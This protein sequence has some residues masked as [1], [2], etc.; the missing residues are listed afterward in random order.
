LYIPR[1]VLI[2]VVLI[3]FFASCKESVADNP[4]NKSR[5]EKLLLKGE[6]A[7]GKINSRLQYIDSA[8]TA[9][10][11]YK[12]D[13]ITRLYYRRAAVAYFNLDAYRKSLKSGKEVYR[14]GQKANDSISMAK[15]LYFSALSHYQMG[16]ND[17]AF[18]YY[19]GAEKLYAHLDDSSMLGEVILYKAYIY[20]H[21]G[22]YV[23][24]ETEA[25]K[26]LKLFDKNS[27]IEIYNCYLLIANALE[28]QNNNEEAIKY[29]NDALREVDGFKK[30]G[31]DNSYINSA[32]ATCY[33][34][35]GF[36]YLK[37]GDFIK[38][39]AIY[40]KALE[41]LGLSNSDTLVYARLLDNL[42]YARFKSG[43][44][45]NLPMLFFEALKL[46]DSLGDKAGVVNSTY[47]LGEYYL[48]QND[49]IN[50]VTHISRAYQKAKQIKSYYDIRNSLKLLADIDKKNS[51]FY[52][53][54]YVWVTDSLAE[55]TLR[56]REKFA[57]VTYE[58]DKLQDENL[59]LAR[60][61]SLIIG[62]A[63][64]VLLFGGAVFI[65]Y[66]L[67]SR[68][69]E[70]LLLQE[71]Q[72]ANEEI[73][74]LMFEQQ[75]KIDAAR[76]E[77][78]NRIA[79]ELHDGILNNIYAV[80]LNLEFSNRKTDD[81]TVALRKGYIKELQ[82]VEGEIRAVSHNLSR[83]TIFNQNNDFAGI[84]AYLVTSQ[85]NN[86]E[87][88][89]TA[90][91][92]KSIDWERVPGTLKINIYRI[93]QEALQNINKYSKAQ[94]ADLEI[95]LDNNILKV[96]ITDNGVG[97]DTDEI[98]GGIGLKN[99]KERAA[100]I[101]GDLKVTSQPGNGTVIELQIPLSL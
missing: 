72:K 47:H 7:K 101:G 51:A 40:N 9:L 49:T 31:Y 78:K 45:N 86:F 3:L 60:K 53:D 90:Y 8:Y 41:I 79:M 25:F 64:I 89:F 61:N 66:Y 96:L 29:Y 84:L 19:Q 4:S 33:N 55:I 10:S 1:K 30:L 71:Q 15:G 14:L 12:N 69:K 98:S 43:N 13:S 80:R 18:A 67:N 23:Y 38:A 65:I 88:K 5:V 52:A 35:I 82:Q 37:T 46:R 83:N 94:N 95:N 36:V 26:A 42:A 17:T 99:F 91:I 59:E 27:A 85:K 81:E 21:M 100:A 48:A 77:E 73:Y 20:F 92:D 34:N 22:E 24:S 32:K 39:T 16:N 58:T 44:I 87:T 76:D 62:A 6:D 74:Q 11:D 56:N 28:G 63:V 70:L 93:I 75:G 97:F 57:R 2:C 68:N 54:R 50:A